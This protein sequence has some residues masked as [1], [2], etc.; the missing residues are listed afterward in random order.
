[1][2]RAACPI[3]RGRGSAFTLWVV[4]SSTEGHRNFSGGAP[5]DWD[6]RVTA[7]E[8][9]ASFMGLLAQHKPFGDF[10]LDGMWPCFHGAPP[11]GSNMR[12][13]AEAQPGPGHPPP[14]KSLWLARPCLHH[15]IQRFAGAN[16]TIRHHG[17][18]KGAR[19]NLLE[20]ESPW[21]ARMVPTFGGG[22]VRFQ[23]I[24]WTTRPKMSSLG[25]ATWPVSSLPPEDTYKQIWWAHPKMG[26]YRGVQTTLPGFAAFPFW[27]ETL[28]KGGGVFI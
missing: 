16:P 25:C 14:H 3:Q 27:R 9:T 11:G 19:G 15:Q 7:P 23:E 20:V 18:Y 26:P 8:L 1:M 17:D 24:A 21:P 6:P 4:L 28:K 22:L 5:N 12:A 10:L 13:H 2:A